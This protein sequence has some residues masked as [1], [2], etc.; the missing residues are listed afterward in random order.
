[1]W[2]FNVWKCC[3]AVHLSMYNKIKLT[4][5]T[6]I[7]PILV[8]QLHIVNFYCP[9]LIDCL[10]SITIDSFCRQ[11]LP[12]DQSEEKGEKAANDYRKLALSSLGENWSS[13][14]RTLW[15][16][17]LPRLP[18]RYCKVLRKCVILYDY[19]SLD[20]LFQQI[21]LFYIFCYEHLSF[22]LLCILY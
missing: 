13:S 8:V 18:C 7:K 11:K 6:Q 9:H 4:C 14:G 1:M 15:G 19:V 16:F 5:N 21:F 2:C 12:R 10:P 17:Y 20:F 22:I 3:L